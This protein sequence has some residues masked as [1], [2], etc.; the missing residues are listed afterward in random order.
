MN[1]NTEWKEL[2]YAGAKLVSEKI[3]IF[4]KNMNRKP[5]SGREI[6]L[7]TQIKNL[8]QE[9]KMLRQKKNART[10]WDEKK[11]DTRLRQTLQLEEINQK[12]WAKKKEHTNNRLPDKQINFGVK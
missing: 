1:N 9:A 7:E 8:R 4:L 10:W 2:I 6:R 3:G 12:P 5:K 11:K